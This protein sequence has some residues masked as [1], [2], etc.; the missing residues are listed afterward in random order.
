MFINFNIRS[1]LSTVGALSAGTA[2]AAPVRP[3]RII[4]IRNAVARR[5][6]KSLKKRV[7]LGTQLKKPDIQVVSPEV[8]AG[9][10]GTRGAP[11]KRGVTRF[12]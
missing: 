1:L 4:F 12:S 6:V 9:P 2:P 3:H 8:Q 11:N 7:T 10:W 5:I